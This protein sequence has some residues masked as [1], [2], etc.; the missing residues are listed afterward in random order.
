MRIVACPE[1][2]SV[3]NS[4]TTCRYSIWGDVTVVLLPVTPSHPH[5]FRTA[6]NSGVKFPNRPLLYF[7]YADCIFHGLQRYVQAVLLDEY[8]RQLLVVSNASRAGHLGSGRER[9]HH[10]VTAYSEPERRRRHHVR[11]LPTTLL[12]RPERCRWVRCLVFMHLLQR[13]SHLRGNRITFPCWPLYALSQL[14]L[15]RS[16][17]LAALESYTFAHSWTY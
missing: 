15:Q 6:F 16:V 5:C 9:R 7:Q 14:L 2:Q 10:A 13:V 1:L 12:P 17:G 11:R 3:V 8:C 4:A